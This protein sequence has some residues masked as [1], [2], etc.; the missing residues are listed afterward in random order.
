[1]NLK[2]HLIENKRAL[3]H[4]APIDLWNKIDKDLF[5]SKSK[6]S[7]TQYLLQLVAACVIVFGLFFAFVQYEKINNANQEIIAL[8]QT[9]TTLLNDESIGHR[10]KAVNLSD[11]IDKSNI[12]IA[13]VL[14][15]TM[16]TDPSKNVK[17]AA[18]NALGQFAEIENVRIAIIDELSIAKDPYVQI[19]LINIL[20]GVKEEK[21]VP[22]LDKIIE[23]RT[24]SILVKQ[25]AE[26]GRKIIIQT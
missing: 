3:E 2:N 11:N 8:K 18:I 24:K 20:S 1:M 21:A 6:S 13:E 25:K 10:I 16:R 17:L 15:H 7:K 19:K 14:I 5:V 23:D 9:M 22:T 26:E 4:S 12:E